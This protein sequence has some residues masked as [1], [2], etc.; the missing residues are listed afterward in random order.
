MYV[1]G[2][3]EKGLFWKDLRRVLF[4][5]SQYTTL[6]RL[7]VEGLA[8]RWHP[9]KVA[10]VLAGIVPNVDELVANLSETAR[11]VT[12]GQGRFGPAVDESWEARTVVRTYAQLL[13]DYHDGSLASDLEEKVVRSFGASSDWLESVDRRRPVFAAVTR[14]VEEGLAVERGAEA[15]VCCGLRRAALAEVGFVSAFPTRGNGAA[16]GREG[17]EETEN[18][19]YLEGEII[20]I[21][22]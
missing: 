7:T 21:Y 6:C 8:E 9:V 5:G 11:K 10:N 22:W 18:A 17:Q 12:V 20:G 19:K 16:R 3:A 13:A 1:V 14:V 2:V 4:S 15:D